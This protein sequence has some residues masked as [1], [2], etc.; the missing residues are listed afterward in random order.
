MRIVA[1]FFVPF[2]VL[3]LNVAG[4]RLMAEDFYSAKRYG[5]LSALSESVEHE[6]FTGGKLAYVLWWDDH[7]PPLF[8]SAGLEYLTGDPGWVTRTTAALTVLVGPGGR[9]LSAAL[10]PIVGIEYN[11]ADGSG[12][13]AVAGA[14]AELVLRPTSKTQVA[15]EYNWLKSFG[16]ESSQQV[17]LGFRYSFEK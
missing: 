13:G 4:S 16:G 12:A 15:A 14:G 2:T 17:G 3:F 11:D 7:A 9:R 5:S 8:F 10:K 1:R 6:D